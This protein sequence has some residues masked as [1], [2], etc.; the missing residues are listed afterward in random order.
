MGRS[1]NAGPAIALRRALPPHRSRRAQPGTPTQ[2]VIYTIELRN[3]GTGP[4]ADAAGDELID[5]LPAGLALQAASADSGTVVADT[6]TNTVRWNGALAAGASATVE[7]RATVVATTAGAI[8]NRAQANYDSDG[9]GIN[10]A[11][12]LSDDPTTPGADATVFVFT[13]AGTATPVA[14]PLSGPWTLLVLMLALGLT[15]LGAPVV[16]RRRRAA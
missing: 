5:T 1:R 4:Q 16:M 8:S 2:P 9:D 13:P 14:V 10:D 11:T 6:A 15:G 3:T 12:A 7:I